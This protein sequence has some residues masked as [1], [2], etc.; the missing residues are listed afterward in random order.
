MCFLIPS[1]MGTELRIATINI[2]KNALEVVLELKKIVSKYFT[3]FS[4]RKTRDKI[5]RES[6]AQQWQFFIKRNVQ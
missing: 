3:I 6:H 2:G 5:E 4:T 1:A